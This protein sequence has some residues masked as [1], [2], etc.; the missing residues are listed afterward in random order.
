M[1]SER[2]RH[3]EDL[4]HAA[5]ECK[6][7]AREAFLQDACGGDPDLRREVESLLT[8]GVEQ[9]RKG[10]LS[11]RKSLDVATQ[12]ADGLAAAHQAHITHRDLKPENIMLTRDGRV[13]ILDFGLALHAL[14]PIGAG[15]TT[16]SM[17]QTK[18]GVLLG[19]LHYMSP[20]QASGMEVDYRS[21]QFSFGVILYEMAA[22]AQPYHRASAPATLQSTF[23][24]D[25]P[26]IPERASVSIPVRWIIARLL[27]KEPAERLHRG[28]LPRSAYASRSYI[29]RHSGTGSASIPAEA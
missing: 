11:A 25:P 10:P 7:E 9:H 21:D 12:L 14:P 16:L 6:P 29:V 26:A 13:K 27:S 17:A 19:T 24:E 5:L 4:Y 20:E 2:Q 18:P 15:D 1:T 23:S 3:I 22:S 8:K 28:P